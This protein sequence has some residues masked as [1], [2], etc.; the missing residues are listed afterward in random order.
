MGRKTNI[1]RLKLRIRFDVMNRKHKVAEQTDHI[2]INGK[3][4]K[5]KINVVD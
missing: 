3:M 1:R 4:N 5:C 2:K